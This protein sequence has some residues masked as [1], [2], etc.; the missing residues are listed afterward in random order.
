[1]LKF[2]TLPNAQLRLAVVTETYPP[3]VN[4]VAM[5]IARL[6]E[7]LRARNHSIQLVRP[8]QD[9]TETAGAADSDTGFHEVLMR[10]LP[11]PRYPHLKMGVPSK[12][13]LVEL[14]SLRRPDLV[15]IVTE[16]PLGWSA[17]QAA[18]R[19]KLPVTSD[20]RTNFH[21]YSQ[22]YGVGW[23]HRPIVALLRKLHNQTLCTFVPTEGLRQNLLA[24][25]FEN[26]KVAARGVDTTLFSPT[27]RSTEL[28]RQWG[29]TDATRVVLSVGRLAAEKN[30]ATVVAA[31]EALQQTT[32]DSRLV[33]VGDG[34]ERKALQA[35]CPDAVF[36]G[37]Q[38]GEALA[39]HY[40]YERRV[41][42]PQ[43]HRDFWQ[44]DYR[45]HGQRAGGAGLRLRGRC[46][47]H[48]L[49]RQRPAGRVQPHRRLCG[50]G[51]LAGRQHRTSSRTGGAGAPDRAGPGL[52]T[53]RGTGGAQHAAVLRSSGSSPAVALGSACV[54][55]RAGL[56][57]RRC[58][59]VIAAAGRRHA[60]CAE[61]RRSAAPAA[62]R[63]RSARQ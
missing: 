48:P 10:G 45:G 27:K 60:R 5:T 16:G 8:R 17:L 52:G 29:A 13:A 37:T 20:F 6:V 59:A 46:R 1:M 11:I 44:C 32:P 21:A 63:P 43:H 33:V 18:K 35:R 49:R 55:G 3:E 14:W 19:L 9:K 38:L 4:G 23:L 34:P 51:R 57:W 22:H 36:A 47:I 53:H 50:P 2:A 12:K 31:Y 30:L 54:G 62:G 24:H 42:V 40:A 61:A 7:G 58:S 39:A 26:L 25:G 41:P 28:R 15:H 56:V